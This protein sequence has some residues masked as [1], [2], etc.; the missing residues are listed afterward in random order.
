VE[1]A[2]AAVRSKVAEAAAADLVLV[3]QRPVQV[4]AVS[5]GDAADVLRNLVL[6]A[7]V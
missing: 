6:R 2:A 1:A 4:A 3:W 7:P 5:E